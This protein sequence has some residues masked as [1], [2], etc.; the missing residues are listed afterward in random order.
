[1]QKTN[2][3]CKLDSSATAPI[4][5]RALLATWE[6]GKLQ[7]CFDE[8]QWISPRADRT[9]Y[10]NSNEAIAS[11]KIRSYIY[12]TSRTNLP[13]AASFVRRHKTVYNYYRLI[14]LKV[15][16]TQ[17]L[18]TCFKMIP[19]SY[20]QFWDVVNYVQSLL[21]TYPLLFQ[22]NEGCVKLSKKRMWWLIIKSG[23]FYRKRRESY[24]AHRGG[25]IN[26]KLCSGAFVQVSNYLN[27]NWD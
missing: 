2:A 15:C 14:L 10:V 27:E 4:S 26:G 24:A 11:V 20:S 18:A 9:F 8:I 6:S 7:F 12:Q 22:I 13:S 17:S 23:N 16:I 1:M 3:V 19:P 25:G 21:I 5:A